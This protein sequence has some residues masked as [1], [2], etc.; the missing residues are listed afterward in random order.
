MCRKALTYVVSTLMVVGGRGHA[1]TGS[2]HD[3]GND[4]LN[5]RQTEAGASKE[6][7][8]ARKSRK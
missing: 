5:A 1:T 3:K 7:N 6:K 2:L 8:N 4:V